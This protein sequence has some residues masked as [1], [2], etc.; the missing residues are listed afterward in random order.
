[1]TRPNLLTFPEVARHRDA[2]M[3]VRF[4]IVGG[5]S[6]VVTIGLF[7]LL[8]H[9]GARPLLG[10]HP[11]TG[12]VFA[13]LAGLAVNYAGNRFWSFDTGHR[14]NRWVE[15][16]GFLITNAVAV[17]IPSACLAISRYVLRLDSAFSDNLS[18]NVIGLIL[19]TLARWLSYRYV[20]FGRKGQKTGRLADVERS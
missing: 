4:L 18:A 14:G 2:R 20:V 19:A 7:N 6:T 5:I 9:G 15:I 16:A 10:S 8:V 11:V 17:G 3:A 12:Y 13:M 1:V